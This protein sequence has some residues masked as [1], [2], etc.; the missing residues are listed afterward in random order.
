MR[1]L[2]RVNKELK[3]LLME[4]PL[5]SVDYMDLESVRMCYKSLIH[6]VELIDLQV[7]EDL[8]IDEEEST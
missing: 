6:S 3:D 2:E 1:E 8:C 7:K 5:E 4:H